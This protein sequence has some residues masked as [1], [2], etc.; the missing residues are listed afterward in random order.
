MGCW[1][2]STAL[3]ADGVPWCSLPDPVAGSA[4]PLVSALLDG[5]LDAVTFTSAPAVD[6]L[7]AAAKH[8]GAWPQARDKLGAIIVVSVGPVTGAALASHGIPVHVQPEDPRL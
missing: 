6:G 8:A 4:H 7:V 5:E 2:R 1:R 3:C